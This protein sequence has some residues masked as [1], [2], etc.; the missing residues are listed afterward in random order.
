MREQDYTIPVTN[1][2]KLV[3]DK[4]VSEIKI[5]EREKADRIWVV[6]G[7]G[8][9]G[10]L[11][12]KLLNERGKECFY[13]CDRNPSLL[14]GQIMGH[15]F[16]ALD[17][18][19]KEPNRFYIFISPENAT[20]ICQNFENNGV[21]AGSDYVCLGNAIYD[22]YIRSME[23]RQQDGALFLGDCDMLSCSLLEREKECLADMLKGQF[24]EGKIS[25]KVQAMNAITIGGYYWSY[26]VY[27]TLGNH[28]DYVLIS[29]DMRNFNGINHLLPSV[30]HVDLLEQMKLLA[31]PDGFAEYIAS[32]KVRYNMESK[33]VSCKKAQG[34]D[35]QTF[36]VNRNYIRLNYCYKWRAE[37]EEVEYLN[38][39]IEE[40]CIDHAT[41]IV[42]FMPI[43]FEKA[44]QY[45]KIKFEN[46]F[47]ENKQKLIDSITQYQPCVVDMSFI[48]GKESFPVQDTY[49]EC[50]ANCSKKQLA[51]EIY[52][53]Y[54]KMG[55][56]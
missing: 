52:K 40:I 2:S 26:K 48:M 45:D 8:V 33:G 19:M 20:E 41:P 35:D 1:T 3:Y 37:N 24:G 16:I 10:N 28:A 46:G 36:V 55:G 13:F 11:L 56:A 21:K 15:G 17:E 43:N 25:C 53:M 34:N 27:K 5:A 4:M 49:D 14:Q 47:R 51:K 29:I 50:L 42:L 32:A 38:K 6:Y 39:L 30:Q 7:A 23:V 18:I 9:R 44:M 54:L 31:E 12:A 22:Q